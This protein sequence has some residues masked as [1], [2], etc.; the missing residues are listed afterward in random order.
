MPAVFSA[1]LEGVMMLPHHAHHL[2]VFGLAAGAL[3]QK[4]VLESIRPWVR[5]DSKAWLTSFMRLQCRSSP[6]S[7]ITQ[8][9][10][11]LCT[12]L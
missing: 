11:L 2:G 7:T 8:C 1:G 12:L 9:I 5:R 10:T 6:Q 3:H 4:R